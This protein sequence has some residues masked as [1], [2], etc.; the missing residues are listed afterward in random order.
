MARKISMLENEVTSNRNATE[1]LS[2][3]IQSGDLIQDNEGRVRVVKD[4]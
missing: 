1:I 4:A 3:M 2:E